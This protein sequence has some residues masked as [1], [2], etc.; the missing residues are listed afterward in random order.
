MPTLCMSERN[1][2]CRSLLRS[3]CSQW[4]RTKEIISRLDL[5]IIWAQ[6]IV[7]SETNRYLTSFQL[8]IINFWQIFLVTRVQIAILLHAEIEK[9]E[10]GSDLRFTSRHRHGS[11]EVFGHGHLTV[12]KYAHNPYMHRSVCDLEMVG[13][14][15]PVARYAGLAEWLPAW[16][17]NGDVHRETEPYLHWN[18]LCESHWV[19]RSTDQSNIQQIR[20][21]LIQETR[22]RVSSDLSFDCHSSD[23]VW[24]RVSR[25]ITSK[26]SLTSS[27]IATSLS[28]LRRDYCRDKAARR[29][30]TEPA[31][32]FCIDDSVVSRVWLFLIHVSS[33]RMT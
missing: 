17:R 2:S 27:I 14:L 4:S 22:A 23:R 28:F 5:A 25:C 1:S 18:A 24:V 10:S 26:C 12:D 33:A 31:I 30:R 32:Q 9:R 19:S 15:V 11:P 29:R 7:F 16:N 8:I 20:A 3:G 21:F 6:K 13:W